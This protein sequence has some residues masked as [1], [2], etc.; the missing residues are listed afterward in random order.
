MSVNKAYVG[1]LAVFGLSL[2]ALVLVLIR[3]FGGGA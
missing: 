3:L 2:I 1:G